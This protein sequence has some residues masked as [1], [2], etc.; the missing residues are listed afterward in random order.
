M[1]DI[2]LVSLSGTPDGGVSPE[3]EIWIDG[4]MLVTNQPVTALESANQ[5]QVFA[6]SGTW[7]HT[8]A[9]GVY[10]WHK[11]A[12]GTRSICYNGITYNG[13]FYAPPSSNVLV[14][15]SVDMEVAIP[16]LVAPPTSAAINSAI[17][18]TNG[19][20]LTLT[21]NEAVTITAADI[22]FAVGGVVCPASNTDGAT[23]GTSHVFALQAPVTTGKTVTYTTSS[24]AFSSP[25]LGTIASAVAV[26]NNSTVP[27][28]VINS[29]TVQPDG[30]TVLVD[31]NE[32]V[33]M[34]TVSDFSLLVGGTAVTLNW[35]SLPGAAAANYTVTSATTIYPGQVVQYGVSSTAITNPAIGATVSGAA[36]VNNS[37][38]IPAT[39]TTVTIGTGPDVLTLF[40]QQ[41]AYSGNAMFTVSVDGTQIG[42]TQTMDPLALHN[43]NVSQTYNVMGTFGTGTHTVAI[44]FT[45]DLYGGTPTTDRNLYLM[46]GSIDGTNIPTAEL[47]LDS[48]GTQNF[49]FVVAGSAPAAATIVS[50]AVAAN[51]T[52]LT[53][54]FSETVTLPNPGDFAISVA[55]TAESIAWAAPTTPGTSFT[56]TLGT[57]VFSGQTVTYSTSNVALSTPNLAATASGVAVTNGSTAT[58]PVVPT[59]ITSFVI[60]ADGVTQTVTFN[61]PCTLNV[62]GADYIWLVVNGTGADGS[63]ANPG[64]P[65]TSFTG[66]LISPAIVYEGQNCSYG[67]NNVG[68]TTPPLAATISGLPVT[69]NSTQVAGGGSG[70]VT[71]VIEGASLG[72]NG[73]TLTV[74][75]N[76]AVTITAADFSFT[77]GG[78]AASASNTD[79]GT[80]SASHVFTL[81][82]AVDFGVAMTY[83]V[84]STAA[85]SPA[86]ASTV[87]S[88]AMTNN[89]GVGAPSGGAV[90][91]TGFGSTGP[92]GSFETV[93]NCTF[94]TSVAGGTITNRDTLFVDAHAY[95]WYEYGPAD[96]NPAGTGPLNGGTQEWN[97]YGP[98]GNGTDGLYGNYSGRHRHFDPG[99]AQDVHELETDRLILHAWCGLANGNAADASNPN[100]V[101]GILRFVPNFR[102]GS[103]FEIQCIMPKGMYSWPA[104]WLN[105][106]NQN[107]WVADPTQTTS[108]PHGY[109]PGEGLIQEWTAEIDIFDEYGFNNTPPGHY[110]IAG[111]PTPDGDQAY[112]LPGQTGPID[113]P[114]TF[115][116]IAGLTTWENS[117][118]YA[119]AVPDLTA[120][121]HTFGLQWNTDNTLG[122]YLDGILYRTRGYVWPASSAPAQLIA[123][124]QIGAWF[125]DLSGISPGGGIT[126]GWDWH[127]KYIRAWNMT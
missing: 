40:M 1:T 37:T 119:N 81:G 23:S 80:S 24:V 59:T 22:S 51:G 100:I 45:N 109:K 120:D 42:G 46:H 11:N 15:G 34:T 78:V 62:G 27:T 2:L 126:N 32:P 26:T 84:S 29:V 72:S 88:A 92:T 63:W 61:Q 28:Q 127:I 19:T 114:P 57:Q 9:H 60:N 71:T 96:T 85:A 110:L 115:D 55:G 14:S 123:S 113:L 21:F 112:A 68:A 44:D 56:G 102:Q 70:P 5:S 106:G 8:V 104:F 79:A 117:G 93:I 7:D 87:S 10:I 86:L 17:L 58:A 107:D 90:V 95:P 30:L 116:D 122:F 52:T 125:N 66:T 4:T 36:A 49:N 83:S 13:V 12:D 91:P 3:V 124:L 38:Q 20:T 33:F 35:G 76:Q 94:G 103:A 99:S 111:D 108:L 97:I 54:V 105:T 69:N 50:A 18:A 53:V 64:V 31:F 89:S 75:F 82:T 47:T 118:W 74:V 25:A 121:F 67:A 41:D 73:T 65:A 39:P 43:N 98:V 77:A 16:I 6:Y 101:S 48:S